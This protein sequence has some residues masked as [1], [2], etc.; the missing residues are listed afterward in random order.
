M[1]ATG[2]RPVLVCSGSLRSQVRDLI[3]AKMPGAA[4]LAYEEI[5][6]DFHLEPCESVALETV[7]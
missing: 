5:G 2:S 3:A 7:G 4:V 1:Q 6:A